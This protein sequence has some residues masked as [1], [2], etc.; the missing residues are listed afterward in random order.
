MHPHAQTPGGLRLACA[1]LPPTLQP[2]PILA[3]APKPDRR[4]SALTATV[5]YLGAAAALV[6][7]GGTARTIR[8]ILGGGENPI[9]ELPL[10]APS[11]Q[12]AQQEHRPVVAS[13]E[14]LPEPR[15]IPDSPDIPPQVTPDRLPEIGQS[16]TQAR[17]A[18]QDEFHDGNVANPYSPGSRRAALQLNPPGG[19]SVRDFTANPP[20]VL[21]AV[22]PIYPTM[23]RFSHIQGPVELLMTIDERGVPSRVEVVSGHPAFHAEAE[24]AARLWRFEPATL[25]GQPVPARFRL[26][27]AF[28]LK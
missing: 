28:R 27:I 26:T 16:S 25:E 2:H 6:L 23:A 24:R 4:I 11:V 19:G 13:T 21:Q 10:D 22:N 7:L 8:P 12:P 9:I 20:R 17:A 5:I 1:D 3:F 15:S 14:P 18:T